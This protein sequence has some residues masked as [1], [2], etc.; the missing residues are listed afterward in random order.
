[1]NKI[2]LAQLALK[3]FKFNLTKL[4]RVDV[5]TV[6]ND[7]DRGFYFDGIYYSPI[8][9]SLE[10]SMR[11]EGI[12]VA[13]IARILSSVRKPFS[14]SDVYAFD[15]SFMRSLAEKKMR[16]LIGDKRP[17]SLWEERRWKK[18]LDVC[19]AKKVIGIQPSRE[20][21]S[22]C[23]KKGVWVADIQHGVI[24]DGPV[25]YY[26]SR[27][28]V[29]EPRH[30]APDAILCWDSG[31]AR[32][33]NEWSKAGIKTTA[34]EI[35]NPWHNRINFALEQDDLVKKICS[36]F[37]IEKINLKRPSILVT[38]Q[39][40][41][42]ELPNGLISDELLKVIRATSQQYSWK[43]RL[44][45]NQLKGIAA[46]E[47]RKF[48]R[49]FESDLHEHVEWEW[50][51]KAPLP[52]VMQ[53]VVLHLTWSS[54]SGIEAALM[55]VPTGFLDPQRREGGNLNGCVGVNFN[56]T[57]SLVE[58][59]ADEIDKWIKFKLTMKHSAVNRSEQHRNYKKLIKWIASNA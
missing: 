48:K 34:I 24:A 51:T 35:G 7:T 27:M 31:S 26:D 58:N 21:C 11:L 16:R 28:R 42:R 22:A 2:L 12:K 43:I 50:A 8:M 32:V 45:P 14:Y 6:A 19:G 5:L 1:M 3:I 36:S 23:H 53:G 41:R 52:I 56:E 9:D 18:I 39:Y 17:Y 46:D 13:C 57:F 59:N 30:W 20:L 40:D 4:P 54:S 37:G 47:G 25:P 29:K 44:H 33:I 38:L 10:Y 49:L 55:G 15:G